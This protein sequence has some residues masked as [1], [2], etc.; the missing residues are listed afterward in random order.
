MLKNNKYIVSSDTE[1]TSKV[2]FCRIFD[3][4]VQYPV[5]TS[6]FPISAFYFR[7]S[8]HYE[9]PPCVCQF[10]IYYLTDGS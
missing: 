1:E 7:Q 9:F 5:N 6:T 2:S 3:I 8:S 4:L 10:P